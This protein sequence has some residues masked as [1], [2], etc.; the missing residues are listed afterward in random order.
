MSI[1]IACFFTTQFAFKL[2]AE[3]TALK[4]IGE[5]NTILL[6]RYTLKSYLKAV[7]DV[8]EKVLKD[9]AYHVN[10]YTIIH[11]SKVVI[12]RETTFEMHNILPI[13]NDAVVIDQDYVYMLTGSV[14]NFTI[15]LGDA[16]HPSHTYLYVFDSETSY[17][18]YVSSS[19]S[20]GNIFS[21]QFQIGGKG[22]NVC[23]QAS[24]VANNTGYHF[25]VMKTK[26]ANTNVTYTLR[27]SL[28]KLSIK[29]YLTNY[30][31]CRVD[32]DMPYCSLNFSGVGTYSLL[33]FSEPTHSLGSRQNHVEVSVS[34]T[35]DHNRNLV[36]LILLYGSI[37]LFVACVL[38]GVV[39]IT[40]NIISF[41]Q[42]R[43]DVIH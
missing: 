7:A 25:F 11:S 23:G 17:S 21:K 29:D 42:R 5:N 30:K 32:E 38:Y 14:V 33:G 4:L 2:P 31:S 36:Y 39:V 10:Y 41:V 34:W 28:N 19:F 15:C 12:H 6:G 3:K 20:S 37:G 22:D 8:I 24:F 27:A 26:Y 18:D 9:D 35:R 1:G 16:V 43:K 13:A 40:V